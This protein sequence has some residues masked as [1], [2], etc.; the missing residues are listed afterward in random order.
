MKKM[1]LIAV[2]TAF[3]LG[4]GASAADKFHVSCCTFSR[5]PNYTTDEGARLAANCGLTKVS[6]GIYAETEQAFLDAALKYGLEVDVITT[7]RI[8]G[9]GKSH[10]QTVKE[11][12][13]EKLVDYLDK[14][15]TTLRHP[16]I[17]ELN[18]CDE[19]SALSMPHLGAMCACIN[20][21]T[22]ATRPYVNLFPNYAHPADATRSAVESHLGTASY[23]DYVRTYCRTVPL[24]YICYDY[25]PCHDDAAVQRQYLPQYL[26]NLKVVADQ[27]RRTGR[28]LRVAQQ[29]NTH[30]S[31]TLGPTE[32]KLRFQAYAAMAFGTVELEWACWTDAWGSWKNNLVD[33]EGKPTEQYHRLKTVNWEVRRIAPSYM[34]YRNVD[35]Y[36]VD[37]CDLAAPLKDKWGIESVDKVDTG[38][39]LGV[40]ATD[41]SPLLVGDM[42]AKNPESR[43]RALFIATC[44]D[45]A[46]VKQAKH[47]VRFRANGRVFATGPKGPAMLERDA[48]G[49]YAVSIRDNSFVFIEIDG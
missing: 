16:A 3:F 15:N 26:A 46:D 20:E 47:T 31:D 22:P 23:E 42:V 13:L 41:G 24:D 21:R 11:Y 14:M 35:T 18:L 25:Y 32:N 4:G 7:P 36:F 49:T 29:S 40:E 9:G 38:Y 8:C 33:K 48:D 28:K 2:G 37:M 39:F 17:A 1:C 45:D 19:P 34:K 6:G 44:G 10:E 27:A 30:P 12:P 43:A 5:G